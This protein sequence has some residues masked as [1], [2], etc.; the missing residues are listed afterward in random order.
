[1]TKWELFELTTNV[2][3]VVKD[4]YRTTLKTQDMIYVVFGRVLDKLSNQ[5][6]SS[7]DLTAITIIIRRGCQVL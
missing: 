3:F 2:I 5:E 7:K 1:M 4:E 6:L